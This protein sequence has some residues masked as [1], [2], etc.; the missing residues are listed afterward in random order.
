MKGKNNEDRYAALS[1]RLGPNNATPSLLLVIS[2]GIGGHRAGEVAASLA[3]DT[4]GQMVGHSDGARP[5][6]VLR[7]AI[8]EASRVIAKEAETDEAQRGMGATCVTAWI[9][10]DQVYVAWVGDSRLYWVRDQ[11]IGQIT[12]DHTWI[13]E[14]IEFG[15]LTPE[16]AKD[17]PNAHVIR[18]YLGSS[19]PAEPD[20]R[21]RLPNGE[22]TQKGEFHQGLRIRPGDRLL[23]CSDGL[24]DLVKP[25][26]ILQVILEKKRNDALHHLVNLAN[27]R[28]G[29]DNITVMLA[30]APLSM[31]P[32]IPLPKK[33]SE[34]RWPLLLG[35]LIASLG[36]VLA[37]VVGL[38]VFLSFYLR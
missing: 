24:S 26:E 7:E 8:M 14:A 29:H 30:E 36:A 19:A 18:R 21:M 13:Q 33:P 27:A 1:H 23:L 28:G 3:V 37:L 32:T 17:H 16:Q 20:F 22:E 4:I 38:I 6:E 15:A 5:I 34:K 2:D 31:H 10:G 25:E 12:T 35:C 11:A 9:V